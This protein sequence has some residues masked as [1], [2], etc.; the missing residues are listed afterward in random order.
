MKFTQKIETST[1]VKFVVVDVPV[2]YDDEDIPYD[3]P[4][5]EGDNWKATIDLNDHT[6]LEWPEGE[7]LH[8]FMK[9][10]DEGIY[11]LLD[12]D[13]REVCRMADYVPNNLLPGEY[14]DYLELEINEAGKILNWSPNANLIDFQPSEE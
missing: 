14:G 7:K 4:L 5:R 6:I 8:L 9:I 1:E 13:M 12:A 11:T 10:C 2:R 3:A